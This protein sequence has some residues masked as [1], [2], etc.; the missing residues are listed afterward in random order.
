MQLMPAKRGCVFICLWFMVCIVS[1][2]HSQPTLVFEPMAQ[3]LSRPVE[4]TNAGDGSGR[5]FI[6]E[7]DGLVKIWKNGKML[8]KP[9]LDLS[10]IVPR[11]KEYEG[12]FSIAFSP[13]YKQSGIFF[14]FYTTGDQHTVVA[15]YKTS[16]SKADSA[17]PNSAVKL[18]SFSSEEGNGPHFGDLH[19]GEDGYLYIMISDVSK[20]G[21]PNNF[22]QDGKSLFGKLLRINAKVAKAPYYSIPADNPYINNDAVRDEIMCIGFR[23]AWRWSFDRKTGD[24]WIAD[25]GE[26]KWEEIDFKKAG[27]LSPANYGWH[28]YEGTAAYNTAGC[29]GKNNYLFPIFTYPHNNNTGGYAV[30]GGYVYRGTAYPSLYGYYICADYVSGNAWKIKPNAS[31]GWL[32]SQQSNIPKGITGFGEDERGELYAATL[33]GTIYR[34]ESAEGF[35]FAGKKE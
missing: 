21:V 28:C 2:L 25:V 15:R 30:T 33:D 11:G 1:A 8:A 35:V 23:N 5:L 20:P 17:M 31:G 34:V 26:D 10:N 13:D 19:F 7:Q 4:I 6:T 9:F 29:V 16:T 3:N 14:V 27:N 12:L 22:A 24:L 32:I 18:F